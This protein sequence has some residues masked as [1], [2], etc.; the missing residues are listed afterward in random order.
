MV[1]NVVAAAGANCIWTRDL[2]RKTTLPKTTL[3]KLIKSLLANNVIKAV[4]PVTMRNKKYYCLYETE[5]LVEL[6]GGSWYEKG[7]LN[8]AKIDELC[9]CIM[10]TIREAFGAYAQRDDDDNESD[11]D[12][13]QSGASLDG[14][15][16]MRDD[17]DDDDSDNARGGAADLWL[18]LATLLTSLN[19]SLSSHA[20]LQPISTL[21]LQQ[22]CVKLDNQRLI[23]YSTIKQVHIRPS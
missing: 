6:T 15:A 16:D 8:Q 2:K 9:R 19:D 13:E 3:D 12:A 17:D 22:L 23:D 20:T 1:R 5:P 10:T 18:S 7:A 4:R 11:Y 21:E 14:T